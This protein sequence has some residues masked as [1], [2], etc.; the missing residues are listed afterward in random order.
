MATIIARPER[1]QSA[2]PP[3]KIDMAT[4]AHGRVMLMLLLMAAVTMVLAGR[5]VWI[6]VATSAKDAQPLG[7]VPVPPRA[8]IVDRNGVPLARNIDGYAISVNPGRI[9]GDKRVLAQKLAAIFPDQT[10]DEFYAILASDKKWSYLRRR[11]LPSEVSAVNALGEIAIEFPREKQRLYPQRTLAAHLIGFTNRDGHGAQGVE[12]Y[13]DKR[14]TEHGTRGAPLALSIDS[15]A[16]AALEEEMIKGV[17]SQR[18]KGAAGIVLDVHTGEVI[19]MVSVPTYNPNKFEVPHAPMVMGRDG[20]LR[21]KVIQCEDLPL[22][23]RVVQAR[24]ELGSVFK[25]LSIAAAMDAGVVTDLSKTYDAVKPLEIA[26]RRIHDHDGLNRWINVP[27][28]LIHSS[29]IV[30]A[31]IADEMGPAPLQKLFR[32]L[33]FDRRASIQLAEQDKTLWPRDW[34]RL[35]NM[36]A[37]YGHG[38]A[39]TP[40]HLASAY[41]AL[42]NGGMWHPATVL[43]VKPGEQVEGRRVFSSSTSARMRQL[44]RMIVQSG[45]GRNGNAE[46]YRIGAKTGT[47]EKPGVGGYSRHANVV[48]FASAFPM[49]EPKYVV[50][51]VMDEP[52]GSKESFGLRTAAWTSAPVVKAFVERVGPLLGVYPQANRDIDISDLLPLIHEDK[53]PVE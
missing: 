29:N 5:M 21:P 39:V 50:V 10:E 1:R 33:E 42:V 11:A 28:A 24:Y 22:C 48:T 9:M 37:S 27:E 36:T 16:Q 25:P 15:R 49:D 8:D 18:A 31:R 4:A 47:G 46:G 38:I 32:D 12:R 23:N 2:L 13:F 40:M 53:V 19:A 14:L 17:T 34:G 52:K 43:K 3:E 7:A 41:A 44:L 6:G 51:V 45:T 30:T 26:G 35:T 20:K